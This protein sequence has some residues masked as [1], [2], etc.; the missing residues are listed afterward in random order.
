MSK[1]VSYPSLVPGIAVGGSA[2]APVAPV[3]ATAEGNFVPNDSTVLLLYTGLK[4]N[5]QSAF[6]K[7]HFLKRV[8]IGP[9]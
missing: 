9:I 2:D 8:L 3:P 7:C 1:P 4:E 5:C 6:G